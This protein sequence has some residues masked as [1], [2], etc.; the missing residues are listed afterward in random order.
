MKKISLLI[1]CLIMFFSCTPPPKK[2]SAD[3]SFKKGLTYF[4]KKDYDL[5]IPMFENTIMEA[6]NP[7]IAAKAQLFLADSYFLDKKYPEAIPAY[8]QYLDIYGETDDAKIAM[9]RLGLS[10]YAL[11]DTVDRDMSAAEG[12][13]KS[14]TALREKDPA[15]AKEY[16]LTKKIVELRNMLAARELYVAKF[17]FRIHKPEAGAK[18][19]D[20][21]MDKYKDTDS[22]EDALFIYGG[23]Y[24]AQDG[25]E[26]EAVKYYQMLLKLN[27]N[28]KYD[29]DVAKELVTLLAKISAK[30]AQQGAK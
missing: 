3:D 18:R 24:A 4:Q 26:A 14:F 16:D 13:L 5:A 19:L 6:D 15:Y 17:Y 2:L 22:Y 9:L 29:K 10:H 21:I 28:T 23:Y 12:A 11:I 1:L 27:P 20:Y 30:L 8:E 25:K 7:E